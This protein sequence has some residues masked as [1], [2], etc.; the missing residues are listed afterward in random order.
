MTLRLTD[1][2]RKD[3]SKLPPEDKE[4]VRE[5][6]SLLAQNAQRGIPLKGA[7]QGYRRFRVGGFRI[8]Y[9]VHDD[10]IIVHYVRPRADAYRRK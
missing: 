6:V 4:R 3:I 8:I 10:A 9:R 5:A 7:W 1:R 2:A